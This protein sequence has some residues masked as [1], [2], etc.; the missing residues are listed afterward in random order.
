MLEVQ[1]G[2]AFVDGSDKYSGYTNTK[3]L[4]AFINARGCSSGIVSALNSYSG[5]ALPNNTSG[6]YLPSAAAMKDIAA[7]SNGTTNFSN[8]LGEIGGT[9]FTVVANGYWTSS[10]SGASNAYAHR[11]M[12]PNTL[13]SSAKTGSKKVRYVFAF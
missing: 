9:K 8:T 2:Y 5:P 7:I 13:V 11:P 1:N 3:A 10:E 12:V 4:K 6:Y